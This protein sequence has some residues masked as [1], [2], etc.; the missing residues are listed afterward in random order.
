M[1]SCTVFNKYAYTLISIIENF[2]ATFKG[3]KEK[4]RQDH[5]DLSDVRSDNLSFYPG[6]VYFGWW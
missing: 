2:K 6:T 5:L 1:Y 4:K 3:M